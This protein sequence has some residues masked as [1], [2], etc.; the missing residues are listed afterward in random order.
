M[1]YIIAYYNNNEELK[2]LVQYS[3]KK[4]KKST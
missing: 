1:W 3:M 4:G 2:Y